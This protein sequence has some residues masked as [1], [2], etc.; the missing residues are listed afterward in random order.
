MSI[1]TISSDFGNTDYRVAAIKGNILSLNPQIS[2]V[3][4][5]HQI[6]AHNLLQ[7]SYII[8]NAYHHFPKKTIHLISIDSLYHPDRRFLLFEIDGHYFLSADNGLL[9]ITFPEIQASAVYEITINNRF[10]DEVQCVTRD[11]FVPVANHLINGGVPEVIGRKIKDPKELSLPKAYYAEAQNM[12]LGEII[13]IDHFGNAVAN[14]T[15]ELFE[16]H[17]AK[18]K[19]FVIKFR[20][21]KVKKIYKNYTDCIKN[22][23]DEPKYYGKQMALFND[24]HYLEIAIYKGSFNNGARNLLGLDVG[25]KIYIEFSK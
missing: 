24:V 1:I 17:S 18:N 7:A 6:Q 19:D 10:D 9:S 15:K 11:I 20:N 4:I 21:L 22:Y 8:R 14:I 2:I 3:D 5:S 12:I 25:E 13:Y 16:T 23:Q